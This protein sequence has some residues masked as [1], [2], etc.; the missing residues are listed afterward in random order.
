MTSFI[1]PSTPFIQKA[2]RATET[3]NTYRPNVIG[4]WRA[5]RELRAPRDLLRFISP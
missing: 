2:T 3:R 4:F 1:H 5:T